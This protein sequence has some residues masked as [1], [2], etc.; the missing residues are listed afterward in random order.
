[1]PSTAVLSGVGQARLAE[2]KGATDVAVVVSRVPQGVTLPVH[3]L[4]TYLYRGSCGS[5]SPQPERALTRNVL[6]YAPGNWPV[7]GGPYSV[8]NKLDMP[9]DELQSAP[10]AI[11]VKS[12]PA[13]GGME[14]Y[15][16]NIS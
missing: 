15:C 9:L 7:F 1:M 6:T 13:D 3:L 16:G 8:S 4:Y 10:H 11:L 5:L 14:M 2:R 12:G